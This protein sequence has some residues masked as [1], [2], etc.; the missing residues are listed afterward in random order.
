M[1]HL[2]TSA[3]LAAAILLVTT[4]LSLSSCSELAFFF[5]VFQD[6][7]Y[8]FDD[9]GIQFPS[10]CSLLSWVSTH[11]TYA[12]DKSVWGHEE[13]WA[14]PE[15]TFNGGKGDCEDKAILF[16][17]FAYTRGLMRDVHLVG[18]VLPDGKGHAIVRQD[19]SYY[20][21]T[22][23]VSYPV[24]SQGGTVMYRLNYGQVMYIASHD[25]AQARGELPLSAVLTRGAIMG[26]KR[27]Q[28]EWQHW[29]SHF[30]PSRSGDACLR[31]DPGTLPGTMDY[32]W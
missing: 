31:R 2:R 21:P 30:G 4:L 24:S 9:G 19:D 5:A 15:Q 18:I 29:K 7:D 32:H 17:Y 20:D 25:H 11:I 27:I 3:S 6:W 28:G 10:T 13:Y 22:R 8:S 1:R 23:G 12:S 16:M 26:G 14:S